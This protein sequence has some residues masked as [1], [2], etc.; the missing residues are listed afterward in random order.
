MNPQP[1]PHHP[2]QQ[3]SPPLR[4]FRSFQLTFQ[5]HIFTLAYISPWW[6]FLFILL[7]SYYLRA[8]YC[9]VI[10]FWT[11]TSSLKVGP[12][13]RD[14]H[15]QDLLG[16]Q[17]K[18]PLIHNVFLPVWNQKYTQQQPHLPL[19]PQK[20]PLSPKSMREQSSLYQP[21]ESMRKRATRAWHIRGPRANNLKMFG[22][23]SFPRIP[24]R[25]VS[26]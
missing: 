13:P 20:N 16:L 9:L 21:T 19:S 17:L 3:I 5:L 11:P 18:L 15:P 25:L 4:P 6:N 12:V 8:F 24:L 10:S 23:S 26:L 22:S 2:G 7:P 1:F 14:L